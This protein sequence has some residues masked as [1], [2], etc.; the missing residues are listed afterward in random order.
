MADADSTSSRFIKNG[1]F[2]PA[3]ILQPD[4]SDYCETLFYAVPATACNEFSGKW[5]SIE[6]HYGLRPNLTPILCSTA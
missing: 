3:V 6:M 5:P 1:E 4:G 2:N